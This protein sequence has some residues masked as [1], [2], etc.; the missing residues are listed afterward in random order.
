MLAKTYDSLEE[1]IALLQEEEELN[2]IRPD[3]D[4]NQIME[5]LGVK[6]S[7]LIGKAYAHMLEIRFSFEGQCGCVD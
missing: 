2:A 7:P 5:I 1:R 3:L 6:P 4:G